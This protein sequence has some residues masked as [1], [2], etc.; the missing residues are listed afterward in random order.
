MTIEIRLTIDDAAFQKAINDPELIIGP[1]KT[2]MKQ[3]TSLV[4]RRAMEIVPVDTGRLRSSI[5]QVV[6]PLQ[7]RVY[8]NVEY[9]P[10]VELGTKPH[11]IRPVRRRAL[12]WQRG[13]QDFFAMRVNHPGS[14]PKPFMRPALEQNRAAIDGLLEEAV[15]EIEEKWRR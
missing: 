1:V 14:R 11:V 7:G 15:K 13:G 12:H 2:F 8:T 3:A 10:H 5:T 6:A 4:Q 9:A